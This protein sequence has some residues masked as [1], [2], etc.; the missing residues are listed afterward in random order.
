MLFLI[1]CIYC[2]R[3]CDEAFAPCKA[4]LHLSMCRLNSR[5]I[6]RLSYID[7]SCTNTCSLTAQ[8]SLFNQWVLANTRLVLMAAEVLIWIGKSPFLLFFF[9]PFFPVYMISCKN[10][11]FFSPPPTNQLLAFQMECTEQ[12]CNNSLGINSI[13][14]ILNFF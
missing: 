9:L 8:S 3:Q 12:I 14:H 4:I 7:S 10:P 6:R 1:C 5:S 2:L 13:T 11:P